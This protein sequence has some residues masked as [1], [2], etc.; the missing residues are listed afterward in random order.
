MGEQRTKIIRLILFNHKL[1]WQYSQSFVTFRIQLLIRY[2][3][4]AYSY[5]NFHDFEMSPNYP[6]S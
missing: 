4:K 3:W 6:D 5:V 2:L 1:Y